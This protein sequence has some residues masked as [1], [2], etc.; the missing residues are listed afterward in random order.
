VERKVKWIAKNSNTQLVYN[1]VNIAENKSIKPAKENLVITV[2]LIDSERTFYLK[3]I[4]TFI[5]VSPDFSLNS[6]LW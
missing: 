2:G 5:E 6:I 1:C 3:G 4:D